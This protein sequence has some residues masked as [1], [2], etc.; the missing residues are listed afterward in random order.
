[1][2]LKRELSKYVQSRDLMMRRRL[3]K[4]VLKSF[5]GNA[6]PIAERKSK[7]VQTPLEVLN[8]PQVLSP[9][10]EVLTADSGAE[11]TLNRN[12]DRGLRWRKHEDCESLRMGALS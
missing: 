12:D 11:E 6:V 8:D 5:R 7:Q 2:I 9:K 1:M 4:R 3:S 10:D